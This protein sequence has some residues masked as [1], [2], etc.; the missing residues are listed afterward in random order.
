MPQTEDTDKITTLYA[1]YEQSMYRE[2]RAILHDDQLAE[3][4]VHE[5]FLRL[6]RLRSRLGEPDSPAVQRYVRR[7]LRSAAIDLYRRCRQDRERCTALEEAEAVAD[8]FNLPDSSL[9][10]L[11]D[12]LPDQYAAVIR[13]RFVRGLSVH[14]TAAV[15]RVS[16]ACIRKRTERAR[17]MLQDSLQ[18]NCTPR[19]E[20]TR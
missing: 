12:S 14:E 17:R 3:D 19:K 5:A 15:L 16:E 8:C 20:I 18:T 9:L 6:I 4:A 1:R 11:I 10:A 7:T 2:A 13:C